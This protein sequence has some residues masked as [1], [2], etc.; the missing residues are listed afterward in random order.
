MGN[1]SILTILDIFIRSLLFLS[2]LIGLVYCWL[3]FDQWFSNR[4]YRIRPTGNKV[5]RVW[6]AYKK[7]RFVCRTFRKP[8]PQKKSLKAKGGKFRIWA[9]FRNISISA[10]WSVS[11]N[12][13]ELK[14]IFSSILKCCWAIYI[15]I[16]KIITNTAYGQIPS[17]NRNTERRSLGSFCQGFLFC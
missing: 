17:V 1:N 11:R 5:R 4:E 8:R 15:I 7:G 9:Y 16:G 10:A 6:I 2:A 12:T 13:E 3:L 14:S